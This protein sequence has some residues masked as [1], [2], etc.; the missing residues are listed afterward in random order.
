VYCLWE[1]L[2]ELRPYIQ[3]NDSLLRMAQQVHKCF[4]PFSSDAIEYARAVSDASAD[5]RRQTE[6]LWQGVMNFSGNT[7]AKDEATF[8]MQQNALVA[9]NGERYYRA[10]ASS[11]PGSWNIRDRHMMQTV[12]RLLEFHGPESK[13][14]VWAHNTHVG[15]ARYTDM[16]AGDMVNLGQLAR[17]EYGQD[18]VYIVGFGSYSGQVIAADEW[19]GTIETM[20]V[21]AAKQG[22]WEALLHQQGAGNKILF[23]SELR[24]QETL[25]KTIGHRAIGVQYDPSAEQ[26]NYVPSTIPNRY[27]AFIFI[28]KTTAL[29]P[30]GT[31]PNNDPPDTYPSGF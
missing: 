1:S 11:Y 21:P 31:Q 24:Q 2:Q 5:C 6:R 22:S 17:E 3:T 12:Q 25:M 8:V 14:I 7:T 30:L 18:N 15:D 10:A 23:S 9:Y 19:G 4:K 27:D 28:D 26:G 13:L 29:H 20:R 16:A